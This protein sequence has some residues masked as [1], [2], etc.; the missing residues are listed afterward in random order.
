MKIK[1]HVVPFYLLRLKDASGVSGTGIV[2]IGAILP[3]GRAV[4]EWATYHSSIGIYQN[5]K[6]VESIHGHEGA[7]KVIM[8]IPSE[9]DL[10]NV[11]SKKEKKTSNKQKR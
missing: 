6:D 4:L 8:G 10:K 11:V 7:T 9:K 5:I 1:D 3:S 2:G